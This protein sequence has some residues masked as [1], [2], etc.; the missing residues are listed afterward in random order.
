M[1]LGLGL[2]ASSPGGPSGPSERKSSL[3]WRIADGSSRSRGRKFL[4]RAMPLA[5]NLSSAFLRDHGRGSASIRWLSRC[6]PESSRPMAVL[7][8]RRTIRR[9]ASRSAGRG[10]RSA[11]RQVSPERRRRSIRQLDRSRR[12]GHVQRHGPDRRPDA[13]VF[14]LYEV[15]GKKSKAAEWRKTF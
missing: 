3:S 8:K 11:S 4:H 14:R 7:W 9:S 1:Y 5:N 2:D 13:W 12:W 10:S 15:W 6:W